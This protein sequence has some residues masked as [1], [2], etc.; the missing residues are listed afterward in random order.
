MVGV[1][2]SALLGL[3]A[4]GWIFWNSFRKSPD[5]PVLLV[6]WAVTLPVFYAIYKVA[7][8]GFSRG[9]LDA[10]FG[11][12]VMLI[13]G[14]V[15]AVLWVGSMTDIIA[16]PF[17]S[18][19]DGGDV[20][21]EP[22]P[23]Y[24]TAISKRKRNQPLQAVIAL[25]EQ[26]AK[27]P[28]DYEGIMM[29]ADVQAEDLKD[30]ASAEMTVNHFCE[31]EKAPPRQ[32][33]AA[34]TQLADWHLKLA[35]DT[36]SACVALERIV[37]RYPDTELALAAKQR[38]AHLDGTEKNIQAAQNRR[39]VFVPEGVKNV[40]LLESSSH[41]APAETP[42]AELAKTYVKHLEE[43]P[44]DTEA[45]EKLA[46]IYV[47]HFKRLDLA[48]IELEQ[49][50]GEPNHPYKRVAHWLNLLADLQIRGGADYDTVRG[51][52]KR[53]IEMYPDYSVAELARSRLAILK[54]EFKALEQTPNK[55]M[56]EYEQNVGLKSKRGY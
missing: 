30:L 8:P 20:P 40:G 45:R 9:G 3:G 4:V 6:K 11:L 26:L 55:I 23:L 5:R 51:T 24:S 38:I 36:A 42:P 37:D 21:P 48:T 12:I 29:L 28:N 44:D 27:F 56:G 52:L 50:I 49:M 25:R 15:L 31:W 39:P 41:L 35:K 18:L 33:A 32:V 14:L 7:I 17:A 43:H 2:V 19:Y 1:I 46:V 34:L 53:I 10:I 54:L 47:N 22:K 13:C 16:K